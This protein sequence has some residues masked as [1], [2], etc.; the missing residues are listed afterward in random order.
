[1][2]KHTLLYICACGLAIALL[3]ACDNATVYNEYQHLPESGWEKNDTVVF[4]IP[5]MTEDGQYKE[6]V[7]LRCRDDY[8]LLDLYLIV[9]Q[10]LLPSHEQVIDTLFCRIYDENGNANGYGVSTFQYQFHL[11]TLP[12]RKGESLRIAIRHDMKREILPGICDIGI[13]LSKQEKRGQVD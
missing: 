3:S 6:E 13:R 2:S 1:M 10:M 9:E 4:D 12:M 11:N 5:P 8:P 7:A